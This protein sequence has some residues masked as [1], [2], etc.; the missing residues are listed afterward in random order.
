MLLSTIIPMSRELT[1]PFVLVR[2]QERFTSIS[3]IVHY[4]GMKEI[5]SIGQSLQCMAI[6]Q[7]RMQLANEFLV[8][9]GYQ[10]MHQG[11]DLTQALKVVQGYYV[12]S[13]MGSILWRSGWIHKHQHLSVRHTQSFLVHG[14]ISCHIYHSSI[15]HME[16][17]KTLH[18]ILDLEFIL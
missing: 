3:K 2:Y 6:G 4:L 16:T 7:T 14:V 11:N 8:N 12:S 15:N 13:S 9:L 5:Q 18:H 10:A 17:S 1:K